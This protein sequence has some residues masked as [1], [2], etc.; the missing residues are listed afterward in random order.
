MVNE[1]TK[2][3]RE[4]TTRGNQLIAPAPHVLNNRSE[5]RSQSRTQIRLNRERQRQVRLRP[6]IRPAYPRSQSQLSTPPSV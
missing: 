4:L 5:S 3:A 6:P 2:K 1:E